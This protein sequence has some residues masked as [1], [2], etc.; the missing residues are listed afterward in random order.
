LPLVP[1]YAPQ[2]ARSSSK[3]VA[4]IFISQPLIQISIA[5]ALRPAAVFGT[6]Q[7]RRPTHQQNFGQVCRFSPIPVDSSSRGL[8]RRRT[9]STGRRRPQA[10]SSVYRSISGEGDRNCRH[11]RLPNHEGWPAPPPVCC[12][13][14]SRSHAQCLTLP[15]QE[16]PFHGRLA[17]R[18]PKQRHPAGV[19]GAGTFQ[20]PC[21]N[22]LPLSHPHHSAK[23]QS[24]NCRLPCL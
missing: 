19:Q 6:S 10:R 18:P 5:G 20:Q 22:R 3:T 12:D 13:P 4:C 2:A 9:E 11:A 7:A 16:G 15:S 23:I 1:A 8:S 14:R 24:P 21:G 17:A